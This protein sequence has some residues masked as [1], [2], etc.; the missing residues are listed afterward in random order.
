MDDD[1]GDVGSGRSLAAP[2]DESKERFLR[3]GGEGL[4]VSAGRI[5]YPSGKG[6]PLRHAPGIDPVSDALYFSFYD[7]MGGGHDPL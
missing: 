4:D 1:I 6:Q 2:F 5:F 7:E 3:P